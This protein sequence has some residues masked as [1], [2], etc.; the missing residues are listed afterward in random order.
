[1]FVCLTVKLTIH[2]L[3]KNRNLFC[4]LYG[5]WTELWTLTLVCKNA[6]LLLTFSILCTR[7]RPLFGLPSFSPEIISNNFSS[8]MPSARSTNKSTTSI[9]A[10]MKRKTIGMLS[11]KEY[12]NRGQQLVIIA[13][14]SHGFIIGV[15]FFGFAYLCQ[16]WVHP[17]CEGLFLDMQTFFLKRFD[18][19]IFKLMDAFTLGH[20]PIVLLHITWWISARLILWPWKLPKIKCQNHTF[21]SIERKK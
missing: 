8:L 19:L 1:M 7:I 9:L 21:Q 12:G 3:Y 6:K 5:E 11:Q 15:C 2:I 10:C 20:I 4:F 18:A 14:V 16:K 13:K 17:F